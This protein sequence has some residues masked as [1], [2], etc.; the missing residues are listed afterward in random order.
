[1]SFFRTVTLSAPLF[2]ASLAVGCAGGEEDSDG[3][4]TTNPST[5]SATATA[6][7]SGSSTSKASTS[8]SESDSGSTGTS[9]DG[10][11]TDG[12]STDGTSTTDGETSTSTGT[13]TMNSGTT[14]VIT[15]GGGGMC[16]ADDECESNS[17]FV[18]PLL[19]GLCGE[20]KVDADCVDG[21]CTTPNPLGGVGAMCNDGSAGDGCQTDA[22]CSDPDNPYCGVVLDATPILKVS[23][24][25]ECKTNADCDA[26]KGN[27]SPDVNVSEF[28]GIMQCVADGSLANDSACN[29]VEQGGVP[30]GNAA[31]AS[32]KCGTAV[33]MGIIKVGVCGECLT[34]ADC[35]GGTC[36]DA[37]IDIQSGDLFGAK[38]I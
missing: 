3:V 13:T 32:G 17:C 19:G 20:C 2:L 5:T 11:S 9:T 31:C 18:V 37:T 38:C 33:L 8:A 30:L 36:Q 7:A 10:T 26:P 28:S 12:T 27:C 6:S 23:T 15:G 14:D 25:G 21:G 34:D 22:V 24:C 16:S 4:S 35:G 29:H 1:M